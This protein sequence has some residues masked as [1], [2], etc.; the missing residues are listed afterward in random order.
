MD[1]LQDVAAIVKQ[2]R[3]ELRLS[4]DDVADLSGTSP[5]FVRELETG[6][7]SVRLDKLVAVLGAL[8]L[9]FDVVKRSR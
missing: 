2:R 9:T 5:R 7:S 3:R 4:Q 1:E 6:K 8:G